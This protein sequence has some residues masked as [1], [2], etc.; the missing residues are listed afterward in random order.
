MT[1]PYEGGCSCGAVR[2]RITGEP[3]AVYCCHCIDC[4]VSSGSAFCMSMLVLRDH[5][6]VIGQQPGVYDHR[7]DGGERTKRTRPCETCGTRLWN[8]PT[9]APVL[10]VKPGTLDDASWLRPAGHIWTR[11][12]QSWVPLPDGPTNYPTQ[13]DDNMMGLIAAYQ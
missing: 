7:I 3:L 10:V 12:A 11:S 5:L 1:P 13:P 2:Y 8:E 6:E 4:Q 9:G